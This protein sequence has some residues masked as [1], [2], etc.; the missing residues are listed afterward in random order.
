MWGGERVGISACTEA[1]PSGTTQE[2]A[3]PPGPGTPLDQAGSPLQQASLD[4]APARPGTLLGPG[5]PP[6]PQ[7]MLGDM[8][9]EW[10]KM[11]NPMHAGDKAS[12][13]GLCPG[14]KKQGSHRRINVLKI[15][16]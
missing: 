1:D 7:C 3:P 13:P 15:G 12:K 10:E 14:F 11:R 9:K 2:Q 4:Q 5:S 6:A 16:F 8:V